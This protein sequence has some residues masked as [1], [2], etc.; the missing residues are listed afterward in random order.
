MESRRY[1]KDIA[2][3]HYDAIIIGS[4]LGGL[5]TANFLARH[6]KKVIIFERHDVPGGFTH[7]FKRKGFEW[8]VGVHYVGQV[9]DKKSLMRHLFDY[10]T[11]SKL[12][13]E[14]M[15]KVYDRAII[16]G[17]A[18][19]FVPGLENQTA[20]LLKTFPTEEVAIKKYF[21]L[22]KS[23]GMSSGLFFGERSMPWFLSATV[24]F[25]MRRS[26]LKRARKTTYEVLRSVTNNEKLISVLC[27]Q[28]G[29][30]GLPPKKSSFAIHAG[31]VDHY[32]GGG[33]YPVG[34]ASSIANN[35]L[36]GIESRGG[37]LIL[38]A[39]TESIVSENGKV[40]GVKLKNGDFIRATQVISNAGA[41]NTFTHLWPKNEKLPERIVEG[42]KLIKPSIAHVCLYVG[43]NAS[44]EELKLPKNNFWIYD[45]YDFDN[46]NDTR[47]KLSST[48]P[49]LTYISFP[50]AKDTDWA[51]IHPNKATV[52]II[53]PCPYEWVAQWQDQKWMKRSAEYSQFKSEWEKSL[54]DKLIKIMPQIEG[55]V[56]HCEVST[57]LST[58]HFSNYG[59]GEIY[60]LEH[61]PQRLR[62]RWLRAHTPIKGLFLTG[63]D[64]VM[65]G[66]GG[67][68]FSGVITA[69]AVLK[70]N[71]MWPVIKKKLFG[72]PNALA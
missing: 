35:I 50:S 49:L 61:T 13:W 36:S 27:S 4:G 21:K 55:H 71:V 14:S 31:L 45:S 68:L 28:C 58:R 18:Y 63:Q 2:E 70:K 56:V 67:A 72:S 60:G 40:T 38:D 37:K 42:L 62:A 29:D 19:D 23:F 44:D 20:Q 43:L 11:D 47:T 3:T 59:S 34:G 51:K 5:T 30:Y 1:S 48:D 65:V 69:I 39:E 15:G 17:D 33:S 7:T 6:G 32:L 64:I 26:F 9:G 54:L 66:V 57:P 24:G 25:F 53:A 46:E 41:R 16:A 12:H 10:V 22:I 8:D 52:Q